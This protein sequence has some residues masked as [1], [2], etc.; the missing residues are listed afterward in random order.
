MNS[1]M[2]KLAIL[3]MIASSVVISFS[4]LIVRILEVGPLVMNFYRGMFLMCAVMVLLVVRYRGATIVR[5]ISVGWSGIIAGIMLAAAAITFLQSLTHTTVANTLFVLAAIPFVTAGLAWIFLKERPNSATLITMVVAFAGIVIMIGEGF[6]IGAAY[7]N[8][9]AL[10]TTLSFSIYAVLV[11]RNRQVDMLPAILISTLIIMAVVA[12]MRQGELEISRQDLWLCLLWGGVMSGFT[13]ACF[14]VA[15][16]HIVAAELTIFMLLEFALGPVWVWLFV[17]ESPSRWTL[18]G[19]ALVI[20]A[21]LG[22]SFAEFRS[23]GSS[24]HAV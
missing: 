22:R 24:R 11:R 2:R 7:G 6:T 13:S 18:V 23:R 1:D 10:L 8:V 9:M 19:G 3:L 5:V 14:I 17:N 4:G 16:R 12:L 15:S 21:V 20:C